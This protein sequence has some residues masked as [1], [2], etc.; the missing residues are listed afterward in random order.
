VRNKKWVMLAIVAVILILAIA[1]TAYAAAGQ[2]NPTGTTKTT[3]LGSSDCPTL[4]GSGTCP[5]VGGS[6]VCPNTSGYRA[7]ERAGGGCCGK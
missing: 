6:G 1:G 2:N 3:C 5:G 4:T 7:C